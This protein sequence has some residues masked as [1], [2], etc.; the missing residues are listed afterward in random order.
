MRLDVDAEMAGAMG[1]ACEVRSVR[2]TEVGYTAAGRPMPVSPLDWGVL[3]PAYFLGAQ[4]AA[5][6]RVVVACP[7]RTLPRT[8]LVRFGE[9][10][11]QAAM[12]VGRRVALVCSADLGHGHAANGPY[13]FSRHSAQ[14]D[15]AY[16]R[17]V[18]DDALGRLLNW[19]NDRVEASLSDSYWQTL[20]L[21]GALGKCEL[22]P[23]LLS[24]E[25]PTYF[26]MACVT[27]DGR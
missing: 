25:A 26:G 13:G 20:M 4:W 15:R 14:H 7:D 9:C 8:E 27:Y 12:H 3:V 23:K 18:R 2:V 11:V 17:A 22:T 19:R 10:V 6:P 1:A 16:C 24:Y 21:H 5:P